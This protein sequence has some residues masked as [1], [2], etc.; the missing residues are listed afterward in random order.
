MRDR[1]GPGRSKR[2]AGGRSRLKP[3][4]Q[5]KVAGTTTAD[6][7][8]KKN[9][10]AEEIENHN[11]YLTRQVENNQEIR[12][13]LHGWNRNY[14]LTE[15]ERSHQGYFQGVKALLHAQGGTFSPGNQR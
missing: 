7:K 8:S 4:G 9:A 12:E 14:L 6:V 15:M 3:L 10:L 13:R 1:A 5:R 2:I 11:I